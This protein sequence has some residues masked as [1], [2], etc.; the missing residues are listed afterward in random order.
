MPG[1]V[2]DALLAQ[3][4]HDD[5]ENFGKKMEKIESDHEKMR[6]EGSVT[7]EE[8]MRRRAEKME[9]DDFI[10]IPTSSEEVEEKKKETVG[11]PVG[12]PVDSGSNEIMKDFLNKLKG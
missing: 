3:M 4:K 10:G 1:P 5:I 8:L 7:I 11:K 9:L 2:L 6:P 12:K